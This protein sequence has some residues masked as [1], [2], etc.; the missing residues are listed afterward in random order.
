MQVLGIDIGGTGIKGCP[1]CTETGEMLGE[2]FRIPTPKEATESAVLETVQSIAKEFSWKGP[3]GCGY[4]GV[5]RRGVIHTAANLDKSLIGVDFAA[6]LGRRVGRPAW[7]VNDADAAG[8]AEMRFGAGKDEHGVVIMLTIGTGI[9]TALFVDGHLVPNLELGH[10]KMRLHKD[11]KY[12]DAEKLVADSARKR[13]DLSWKQWS[14][15]FNRYLAYMQ[16]LINPDLIILGGGAAKKG[17]KFLQYLESDVPI[18]TATLENTAGIIG[19]A[20]ASR[21]YGKDA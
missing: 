20:M 12:H 14:K 19:A 13:A 15:R 18:K 17:D 21:V 1:V 2:R 6:S 5:V 4:P 8:L 3:V 11:P 9:G 16:K 10:V 7:V